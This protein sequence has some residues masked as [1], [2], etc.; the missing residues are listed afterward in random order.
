[1]ETVAILAL[2]EKGI[3]IAQALLAAGQSAVPAF[4]AL[5]ALIA[6]A[7]QGSVTDDMLEQTEATLDGL[8]DDF[9]LELPPAS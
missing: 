3:V 7:K 9:N 4:N 6:G 1:M 2:I 8:I 5:K